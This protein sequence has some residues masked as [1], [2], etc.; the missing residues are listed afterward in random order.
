MFSAVILSPSRQMLGSPFI[1]TSFP[2]HNLWITLSY[3]TTQW[4]TNSISKQTIHKYKNKITRGKKCFMILKW[5]AFS[6]LSIITHTHRNSEIPVLIHFHMHPR[7]IKFSI[8]LKAAVMYWYYACSGHFSVSY[9]V[10][11]GVTWLI[12]WHWSRLGHCVVRM[13]WCW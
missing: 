13:D 3:H 8:L 6:L 9:N 11:S 2:I 10:Y 12:Y 5:T 1:S 7:N 4:V